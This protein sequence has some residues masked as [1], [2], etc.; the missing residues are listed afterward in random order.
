VT[1]SERFG[2]GEALAE[3]RRRG[4][5]DDGYVERI[6]ISRGEGRAVVALG[7]GG[8]PELALKLDQPSAL[9]AAARFLEVYRGLPLVP[10][11]RHVD[12]AY[13][14]LVYDWEPGTLVRDGRARIDKATALLELS[15]GLLC[16]YVPAGTAAACHLEEIYASEAGPPQGRTWQD[17]LGLALSGRHETVRTHLPRGAEALARDLAAAPQRHG[18]G[19]L[20]LLHG[21]CGAH[22]FVVRDGRLASVIDPLPLA[23]E[24]IFELAF[25]FASWPGD[26]TLDAIMPAA[27]TLERA[28][29][30][31][32]PRR[33]T[34]T[35]VEEVVIALYSRIGT[36]VTWRPAD[37]PAYVDAWAHWTG[38]LRRA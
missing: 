17:F 21:D 28:G 35:L 5:I 22:N 32:P 12:P 29:L 24:P 20:Y 14:F 36:F 27:E 4:V 25:A 34:R 9:R 2:A 11:L 30:W 10:T 19:P 31:H 13:R 37:L 15:R 33:R 1:S 18:G 23:G 26:L 7:R 3:M 16:R 6:P 8:G 38:L